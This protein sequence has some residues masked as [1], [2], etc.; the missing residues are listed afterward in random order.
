MSKECTY[1]NITVHCIGTQRIDF[2]KI[3]VLKIKGRYSFGLWTGSTLHLYI[4]I[5]F[6][7]HI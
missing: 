5:T 7:M 2:L 1:Y 6:H 3:A 4:Y